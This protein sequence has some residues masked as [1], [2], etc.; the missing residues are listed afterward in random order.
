VSGGEPYLSR[1]S[2]DVL[3]RAEE[4]A[5]K[6]GDEFVSLEY[7][8]LAL[9]DKKNAVQKMLQDAGLQPMRCVQPLQNYVKVTK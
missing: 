3:L 9:C 5:Q 1:E 6:D 2:N 8:L 7:L 4:L